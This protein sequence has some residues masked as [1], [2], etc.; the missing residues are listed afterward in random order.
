MTTVC[1]VPANWDTNLRVSGF[2]IDN[3]RD[4]QT[5]S[6]GVIKSVTLSGEVLKFPTPSAL[7]DTPKT[8]GAVTQPLGK[9]HVALVED[10]IEEAKRYVKG[11]RAQGTLDLDADAADDDDDDADAGE[12]PKQGDLIK[13][14][15]GKKG[16]KASE[17]AAAK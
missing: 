17:A 7:L 12:E 3:L 14:P 16:A 4:V 5:V 1:E 10:A 8:E 13:L 11:E 2:Q 6:I 15:K 9:D